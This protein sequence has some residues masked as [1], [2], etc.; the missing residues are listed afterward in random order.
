MQLAKVSYTIVIYTVRIL[1]AFFVRIWNVL[2]AHPKLKNCLKG[3]IMLLTKMI[4]R[5]R[6]PF[7]TR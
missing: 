3:F 4:T 6:K 1:T 2:F 7:S 5:L